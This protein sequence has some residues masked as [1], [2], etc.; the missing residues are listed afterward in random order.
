MCLYVSGSTQ[1]AGL[2]LLPAHTTLRNQ[3]SR[4]QNAMF[5]LANLAFFFLSCTYPAGCLYPVHWD[6]EGSELHVQCRFSVLNATR[7]CT[8]HYNIITMMTQ[9]TLHN[10]LPNTAMQ[11]GTRMPKGAH[12]CGGVGEFPVEE[13]CC[14][15]HVPENDRWCAYGG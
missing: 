3:S 5:Q 2:T 13:C 10:R 11:D 7:V 12:M 15:C 4:L 14:W 6:A 9:S 1:L 8:S